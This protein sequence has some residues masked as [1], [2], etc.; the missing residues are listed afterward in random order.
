[1]PEEGV[2]PEEPAGSTLV[3][4]GLDVSGVGD[5]KYRA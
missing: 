2:V 5:F 1:M 4:E 3:I